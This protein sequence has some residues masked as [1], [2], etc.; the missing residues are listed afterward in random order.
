MICKG[1]IPSSET[2]FAALRSFSPSA[3]PEGPSRWTLAFSNGAPHRV[4]AKLADGWLLFAAKPRP[5]TAAPLSYWDALTRNSALPGLVKFALTRARR[6]RL[7][8]ELPLLDGVELTNRISQTA[9]AFQWAWA[10][11]RAGSRSEPQGAELQVGD[12]AIAAP[13][14]ALC[15]EAGWPF[16]ERNGGK[17]AVELE[18]RN[19]FYQA[20]LGPANGGL[21]I[22]CDLASVDEATA[23]CR[24]A[25]AGM[26]L[27]AS[28]VV[29]LCRAAIVSDESACVARL[30]VVFAAAPCVFE[31][32]S[33]LES[34]SV[35]CSLVGEEINLLLDPVAARH[36]LETRG[37]DLPNGDPQTT[38][39]RTTP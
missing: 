16:I 34:L 29:R 35:A 27:A 14:K 11:D 26:L 25:I 32:S 2:V 31:I 9:A 6:L 20:L 12:E 17:L 13:L 18:V 15:L 19:S 28:G 5:A 38:N 21:R 24:Q 3:M 36:Y 22:S 4:T 7:Q 23:V 10:L 1:E 39:E 37:W 30:E 33:A 8:A